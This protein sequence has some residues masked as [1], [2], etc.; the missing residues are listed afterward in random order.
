MMVCH[1]VRFQSSQT[2]SSITPQWGVLVGNN[3]HP[4]SQS[5]TSTAEFLNSGKQEALELT[6]KT[7]T[8]KGIDIQAVKLLSPV[9]KPCQVLCQGANYRQHMVESGMNPDDKNFNMIFNKSA[10]SISGPMDD[11]VR[12]AHVRLLDYEVEMGIV[13][14]K[15]IHEST[16]INDHNIGDYVSGIVIGNDVSAR[17]VQVPQMQFFKGKSYRSFCPVGP[18]LCLLEKED[19]HY[20][21]NLELTLKVNGEVRQFDVTKN[22]VFKPAETLTELSQVSDIN[23]GDLIL[24]GTPAGCAMR[25]PPPAITRLSGLLPEPVKWKLFKKMQSKRAAYLQPGDIIETS[26]RSNDSVVDLGKQVNRVV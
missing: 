9:T 6:K 24:T 26:I 22:L 15:P 23:M 11:V 25:V 21:H 17:D 14:G 16:Q 4:L 20:L 2:K 7:D 8:S 18:V 10:A 12:P 19:M 13:I 5:F 1:V 3:I